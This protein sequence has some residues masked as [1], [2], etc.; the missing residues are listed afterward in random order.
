LAV[1]F[2]VI[3]WNVLTF[4]P[5]EEGTL[6]SVSIRAAFAL[7]CQHSHTQEH[8]G[9]IT[10]GGPVAV[11]QLTLSLLKSLLLATVTPHLFSLPLASLAIVLFPLPGLYFDLHK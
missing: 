9:E 4:L 6:Q 7:I 3:L 5:W 8:Y 2:Y 10:T 11:T 1:E